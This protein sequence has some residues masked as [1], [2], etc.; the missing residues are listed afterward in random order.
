MKTLRA[1]YI[2]EMLA[3]YQFIILYRLVF[4]LVTDRLKYAELFISSSIFYGCETWFYMLQKMLQLR[5]FNGVKVSRNKNTCCS[6]SI[7]NTSCLS[8]P[9][10]SLPHQQR[11][12]VQRSA[13]LLPKVPC[14]G[15]VVLQA[16][17]H[18]IAEDYVTFIIC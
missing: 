6:L 11:R 15:L 8:K 16:T 9:F 2:L 17:G 18:H 12:F 10:F 3:A 5:A 14:T 4:C 7:T 1:D 13:M